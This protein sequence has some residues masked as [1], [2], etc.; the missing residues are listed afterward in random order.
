MTNVQRHVWRVVVFQ[1]GA[2]AI[3][4]PNV[5]IRNGLALDDGLAHV[6][7]DRDGVVDAN[8]AHSLAALAQSIAQT[9]RWRIRRGKQFV[10]K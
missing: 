6:K 10:A 1:V 3:D 4:D 8:A 9:G 2:D 5:Q 7:H